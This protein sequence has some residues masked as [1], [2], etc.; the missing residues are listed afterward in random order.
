MVMELGEEDGSAK[1]KTVASLVDQ[2]PLLNA[3]M[4]ALV[5]YL[6]ETTFCGYYDAV[7]YPASAGHRRRAEIH[8]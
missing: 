3:E 4:L 8:L 1:L 7:P 5:R 6:K 2:E